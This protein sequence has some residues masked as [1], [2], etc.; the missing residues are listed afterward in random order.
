MA[1]GWESKAIEE[2]QAEASEA[3]PVRRPPL[4]PADKLKLQKRDGLLL[5]RKRV[6]QQIEGS[7]NQRYRAMLVQ[8]LADLDRKLADLG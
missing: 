2:Q 7:G 8:A 5:D 6:L 1:R 4:S 3:H